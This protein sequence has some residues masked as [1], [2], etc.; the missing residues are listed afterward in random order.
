MSERKSNMEDFIDTY[1]P[2]ERDSIEDVVI[3][4]KEKQPSRLRLCVVVGLT[5]DEVIALSDA[6]PQTI[7][8]LRLNHCQQ[9]FV[10]R[11]LERL[12]KTPI[13]RLYLFGNQINDCLMKA[14]GELLQA[15]QGLEE[16]NMK[17]NAI[18]SLGAFS[19]A[20]GIRNHSTLELSLI[21]I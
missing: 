4:M 1:R 10:A 7:C 14:V 19:I 13:K 12:K 2:G 8:E 21:H 5:E 18:E 20:E 11:V 16:V 6:I 17:H 9:S 3:N 15:N